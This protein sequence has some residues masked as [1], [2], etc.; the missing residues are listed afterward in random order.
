MNKEI[1]LKEFCSIRIKGFCLKPVWEK[2][3]ILKANRI[4]YNLY[5][6]TGNK[7]YLK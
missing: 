5:L 3:L 1:T 7:E 6:I 4:D 2:S